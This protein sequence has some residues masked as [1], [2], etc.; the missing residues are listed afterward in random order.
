MPDKINPM[1]TVRQQV[2]EYLEAHR[3]ATAE[4]IASA[5]KMT[6][7]NAR[8]H[9]AVLTAEGAVEITGVIQDGSPGRPRQRYS[10]TRQTRRHN[11]DRLAHALLLALEEKAIDQKLL[12]H[13]AEI[14]WSK[15]AT[16]ATGDLTS[17]SRE[18]L[19]R[20]LAR[21]IRGLNRLN[22][23]AR[24]EAHAQAPRILFNHCPYVTII[25]DHPE[26]CQMDAYMLKK[27][28]GMPV[29]QQVKL[30][31]TSQ[32]LTFCMFQLAKVMGKE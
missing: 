15:E 26:L 9:L 10:P 21:V 2:L 17:D 20:R 24:W 3:V 32:G 8:H 1:K 4:E 28:L 16:L 31:A 19:T 23:E 29:A 25:S 12:E 22:Y 7:A 27:A 30:G 18:H 6:G 13:L 5:F 11:L 14:I